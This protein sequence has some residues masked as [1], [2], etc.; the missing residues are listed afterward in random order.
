[1][2]GVA[3]RLWT[4][5]LL[6]GLLAAPRA[7]ALMAADWLNKAKGKAKEVAGHLYEAAQQVK[8]AADKVLEKGKQGWEKFSQSTPGKIA[9]GV[10]K[11]VVDPQEIGSGLKQLKEG[12]SSLYKAAEHAAR[13]EWKQ[14]A[15]LAGEGMA[16][17]GS[18]ALKVGANVPIPAGKF[19][20]VGKYV[21][22]AADAIQTVAKAK[23]LK[24]T[25]KLVEGLQKVT[26]KLLK[27]A[28]KWQ[29]TADKIKAATEKA[30]KYVKG[31]PQKAVDKAVELG[32]KVPGLKSVIKTGEK[33][34]RKTTKAVEKAEKLIVNKTGKLIDKAGKV[35]KEKAGQIIDRTNKGLKEGAKKV[36]DGAA[37]GIRKVL[38]KGAGKYVDKVSG[39]AKKGV[40]KY[41]GK[42]V[43]KQGVDQAVKAGKDY[44]KGK[45]KEGIGAAKRSVGRQVQRLVGRTAYEGARMVGRSLNQKSEHKSSGSVGRAAKPTSTPK[46]TRPTSGGSRPSA[47]RASSGRTR[48][49]GK[50]RSSGRGGRRR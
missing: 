4:V 11:F 9:I 39:V 14:A 16:T 49:S 22:R 20:K 28:E 37:G 12:A 47:S 5:A 19:L 41:L 27:G 18:G 6:P 42:R 2:R 48:S 3:F 32:K 29:K 30:G 40:N 7:E 25:A 23:N 26:G 44:V 24:N 46:A 10:G 21:T 50:A 13:G 43:L 45:V 38:P 34:V 1:M 8:A 33:V 17:V 35:V 36:I 31:L 15:R